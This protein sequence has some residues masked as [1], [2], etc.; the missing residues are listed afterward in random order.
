MRTALVDQFDTW[1]E[2]ADLAAGPPIS[3][4]R[5]LDI[6]ASHAGGDCSAGHSC[7]GEIGDGHPEL[8]GC[9]RLDI[10]RSIRR[11]QETAFEVDYS[12]GPA[13]HAMAQRIGN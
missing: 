8:G 5:A 12:A 1:V 6:V 3:V 11:F 10:K 2:I 13:G 9:G 7:D 4:L